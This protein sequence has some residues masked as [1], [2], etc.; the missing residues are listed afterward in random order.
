MDEPGSGAPV[1]GDLD[2]RPADDRTGQDWSAGVLATLALVWL[3]ALLWAAYGSI[4]AAPD[5]SALALTQTALALPTVI[6][7]ALVAGA[8]V[9]LVGVTLLA[10]RRPAAVDRTLPRLAV[11]L[12]SG[13]AVGS[14]ALGLIL[15]GYGGRSSILVLA[16]AVLTAHALGGALAAVRPTAVLAAAVAGTL[17]WFALGLV[18][19]A[20]HTPLLRLFGARDTAE[21]WYAA[22]GLLLFVVALLGGAVAGLVAYGYLRRRGGG[23]RWPAYLAAGAGPGLF[24][25]L[26]TAVTRVGG[27][28]LLSLATSASEAD[29]TG[30][31]YRGTANL[32]TD[33]VLLF[34][35]GVAAT[36]AF[37]RRLPARA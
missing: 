9:A 33:L 13:I 19:G 23:L 28:H 26:S 7:A 2:R 24:M 12:A 22:T 5:G 16:L 36:V 30:A 34:V 1:A 15:A 35:G 25:L 11:G 6:S 37:G 27:G 20:F 29:A 3:A 31:W 17:G 18:Q 4:G 21:S 32:S 8:A 14:A 10:R